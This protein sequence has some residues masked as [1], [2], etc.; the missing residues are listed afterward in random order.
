MP[1]L[2][3]DRYPICLQFQWKAMV[4]TGALETFRVW[5]GVLGERTA[6]SQCVRIGT[7]RYQGVPTHTNAK[8]IDLKTLCTAGCAKNLRKLCKEVALKSGLTSSSSA[9]VVLTPTC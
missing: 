9:F 7:N 5:F 2:E 1:W 3:L 8:R 6:R 4:F